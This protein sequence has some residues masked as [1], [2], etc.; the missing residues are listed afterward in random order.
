MNF[1]QYL[2]EAII[3]DPVVLV[4][5][6]KPNVLQYFVSKIKYVDIKPKLISSLKSQMNKE[7][8][9]PLATDYIKGK[10]KPTD[11][12]RKVWEMAPTVVLFVEDENVAYVYS[13]KKLKE[14]YDFDE[15][16]LKNIP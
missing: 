11:N 1:N 13:N 8:F 9:F 5:D 7:L 6:E 2:N 15:K 10:E 4:Y 16:K 12:F 14:L 3:D